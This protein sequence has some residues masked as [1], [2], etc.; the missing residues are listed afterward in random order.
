MKRFYPDFESLNAFTLSLDY[1]QDELACAHC[2]K[3]RYN[4][5]PMVLFTNN[6]LPLFLK[7]SE[8]AYFVPIVMGARVVVEPFNLEPRKI[9]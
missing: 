6:V 4:L 2:S 7:K 8:N 1:H 5:Y 9:S 3:K